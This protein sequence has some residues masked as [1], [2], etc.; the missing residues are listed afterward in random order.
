[1]GYKLW[2]AHPHPRDYFLLLPAEGLDW[3]VHAEVRYTGAVAMSRAVL[4]RLKTPAGEPLL[5]D[6]R[7]A[8]FWSE[9][10]ERATL[11]TWCGSIPRFPEDWIAGLGRWGTARGEAYLRTRKRRIAEMQAAAV[12]VTTGSNSGEQIAEGL[13]LAD[14]R[15]FMEGLG[16]GPDGVEEQLRRLQHVPGDQHYSPTE[17]SE[18]SDSSPGEVE[19]KS[20]SDDDAEA[21]HDEPEVHAG[22][23]HLE[24]QG[25]L[26]RGPHSGSGP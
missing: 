11:P 23:A 22:L 8:A 19:A 20:G 15:I 6:P 2:Q 26:G 18:D 9:H 5:S 12:E 1:V 24:L 25:Y 17:E 16:A 10:S 21:D 3:V 7:L 14:I 13:V 4:V